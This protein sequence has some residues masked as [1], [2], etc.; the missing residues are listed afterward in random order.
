[1]NKDQ[2]NQTV[3]KEISHPGDAC[4]CINNSGKRIK[5]P[6]IRTALHMIKAQSEVK[7]TR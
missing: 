4:L 5:W 3:I 2:F 6:H 1:M 7:I